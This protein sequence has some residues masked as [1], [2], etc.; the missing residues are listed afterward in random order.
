MFFIQNASFN[1]RYSWRGVAATKEI[2]NNNTIFCFFYKV[3]NEERGTRDTSFVSRPSF[4]VYR[5]S[6]LAVFT[7]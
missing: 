6:D 7:E 2:L 5:F 4:L 1:I 3:S